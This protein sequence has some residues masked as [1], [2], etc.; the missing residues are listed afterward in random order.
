VSV[1][2]VLRS[3]SLVLAAV[4]T[5]ATSIGLVLVAAQAGHTLPNTRLAG[6]DVGNL[7]ADEVRARVEPVVTDRLGR[8][9]VLAVDDDRFVLVP[10]EID[11]RIDLDASVRS[12]KDRGRRGSPLVFVERLTSL[13]VTADLPLVV[14]WDERALGRWVDGVIADSERDADPGGLVVDPRTFEV[15]ARPS[16][17]S[18]SLD[19]EAVMAA[20]AEELVERTD[21]AVLPARSGPAPFALADIEALATSLGAA[22]APGTPLV[23]EHAGDR[24]EVPPALLAAAARVEVSADDVR[25]PALAFDGGVLDAALGTTARRLFDLEPISARFETDRVPPVTHDAQGTTSFSPVPIDGAFLEGRDGTRFDPQ[26]L[27]EQLAGMVADGRREAAIALEVVEPEVP[28]DDAR[29]GAPTHL[30]GTFTTYFTPGQVR[31]TNI[32]LLADVIDGAVVAPGEQFSINDISGPRSCADGYALA[33]TIVAGELI[34]TCGG[35]V[36]QFGTTTFNAAFFAGVRLDQWK[37]HSWYISRYP[38]GREATLTYPSLDVR[39][40]NT[41][42]G[43]LVVRTSHTDRSVTVS[44]YGRPR[45]ARVA[46]THGTPTNVRPAPQRTQPD[47]NLPTGVERVIQA[48]GGGFDVEVVRTLERADGRRDEERIRTVYVGQPRII[49]VGTG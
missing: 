30:L 7:T 45:Y 22:L 21:E 35:G 16:V 8:A 18:R 47:P 26:R 25:R 40:T 9:V 19:R 49:A 1:E 15:T 5:I 2:R 29:R 41:T 44:I 4:V 28:N 31:N 14:E 10:S 6:V 17:G 13:W 20:V 48:G 39:F 46:A 42:E 33:G 43:W 38:M 23:L 11:Y 36:S 34:D 32:R 37:A 24:L 12:A 3:A 27:A